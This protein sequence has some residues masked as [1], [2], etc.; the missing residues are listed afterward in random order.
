MKLKVDKT[1]LIIIADILLIAFSYFLTLHFM[2]TLDDALTKYSYPYLWNTILLAEIVYILA[3]SLSGVYKN[4]L[5]Y[6]SI[7]FFIYV[8]LICLCSGGIMVVLSFFWKG[9]LNLMH[10]KENLLASVFVAILIV[11]IRA[12]VRI[13]YLSKLLKERNISLSQKKL[14]IIGAGNAGEWLI[15]SIT[16]NN[17]VNYKLVGLIDD[18]PEKI[19]KLVNGVEVLGNVDS[20]CNITSKYKVDEIIVT[21]PSMDSDAQKRIYE[22]CTET[23]LPVKTLP[24]ISELM[25][26]GYS[27]DAF[28][29]V[30]DVSIEDL[31]AR[32][33]VSLNNEQLANEITGKTVLVTGGGGSIGSELCRQIAKH[34]PKKLIVLDIYENNAYDLQMEL[35]RKYP[36]LELRVVIAS[37]RDADKI[38]MVV[39]KYMPHII[40]HAAAHK[41]VPLMEYNP[42]ESVKNNVFG[43]YNVAKSADKYGVKKFVLISTDKAVNPTNIMG[44]TKRMCEMI[45]Q[46]MQEVSRTEFVA[47]RFG[48][49][50]G[51]NGSVIP[52][53]KRQIENREPITVTHKEITRFFMTIPEAAQLVLQAACYAHGGEIF[54]LDMGEPVKI[55]DMAINLIKLSGLKPFEDIDV[56]ITGLRPGEK[57]Y[58][59]LLMAEEGLTST[60]NNK[61]FIA[62]P[63]FS[64]M[65]TLE[66]SLDKLRT[67][68]VSSD[69]E[70][71]KDTVS[72]VVPT[73]IRNKPQDSFTENIIA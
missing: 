15:S 36:E 13:F 47:V 26:S 37:V 50:L 17:K 16:T 40:F 31:L 18:N 4:I 45:I 51:S 60:E 38:D 48:N 54:V 34:A 67:A 30:R 59:E 20:I 12:S 1:R 11:A 53:F 29:H 19:G 49:V 58:E 28:S 21:I 62:H 71:I 5:K 70:L 39:N 6:V 68:M 25:E 22:K 46:S 7:R 32:K 65:E 69:N 66:K 10:W 27:D 14:L 43:T 3:I 23:G 72:E 55:Y 52:L 9:A 42:G 73:Y 61:I 35:E 63:I 24:G 33:P 8:G 2:Y 44:A 64:D 56:V 41:H 57:L